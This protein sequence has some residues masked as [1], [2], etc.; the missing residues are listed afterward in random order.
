[1]RVDLVQ[2]A[3]DAVYS[4]LKA[5]EGTFPFGAEVLQHVLESTRPPY[6]IVGMITSEN[7]A[8]NPDLQLEKLTVEIQ[9]V[10]RGRDR[11]PLLVMMHAA[12]AALDEQPI[13][14]A[15]AE[16]DAPRF[17]RAQASDAI[18]DGETYV[19]VSWFEIWAQPG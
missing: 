8:P 10:F 19:G 18:L 4:A 13:T 17:I 2:A 16:F 14:A 5:A 1:M 12:R 9:C 3:Q 7:E 11:A 15:G 6:A